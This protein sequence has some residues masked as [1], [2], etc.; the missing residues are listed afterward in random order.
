MIPCQGSFFIALRVDVKPLRDRSRGCRLGRCQ[1][2]NGSGGGDGD[3]RFP[4]L[5]RSIFAF[6]KQLG[7]RR[8]REQGFFIPRD[9][10]KAPKLAAVAK[11]FEL[12]E[13]KWP[14]YLSAHS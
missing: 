2:E 5:A 8:S 13:P 10:V 11:R 1:L 7:H 3:W 9:F 4:K 12:L 14:G 6:R